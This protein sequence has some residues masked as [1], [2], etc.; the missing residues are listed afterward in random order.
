MF[1]TRERPLVLKD[2]A[3]SDPGLKYMTRAPVGNPERAAILVCV[4][5]VMGTPAAGMVGMEANPL[6]AACPVVLCSQLIPG[7]MEPAKTEPG[8]ALPVQL[9]VSRS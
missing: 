7:S 2:G 8:V 5:H 6:L 4:S 9:V 3:A 1:I